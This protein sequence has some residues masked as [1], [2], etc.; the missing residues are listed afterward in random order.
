[1]KKFRWIILVMV[2]VPV[3]LLLWAQV[4]NLMCDQ[5]VQFFSGICAINKFIPW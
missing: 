4:V 2:V 3:C 5:D 1:M